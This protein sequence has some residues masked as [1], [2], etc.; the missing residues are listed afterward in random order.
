MKDYR[1]DSHIGELIE[2]GVTS[3]KIEGRLKNSSY[4]KNT[5]RYYRNVL[6]RFISRNPRYR[7]ASYGRIE[8]GFTP[9]PDLTFNRG[10]TKA[11]IDGTRGSWN[12]VDGAKSLGEYIGEV[13]NAGRGWFSLEKGS[14]QLSN[15]DGLSIVRKNGE[16]TGM[17]VEIASGAKI[18]VKETS[19]ITI[20]N[21]NTN[22]RRICHKDWLTAVLIIFRKT[23][24]QQSRL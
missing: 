4:V 22:L 13:A 12:S 18:V 14:K 5:V 8:G 23:D 11:W 1:L 19:D 7:K 24:R 17:R 3:F 10:Y 20:S 16:L 21:S 6:D 9:N 2:S 15:G